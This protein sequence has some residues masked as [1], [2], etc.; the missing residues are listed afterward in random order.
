MAK[1][2]CP[3]CGTL[4]DEGAGSCAL[5][6]AGTRAPASPPV[7]AAAPAA[8]TAPGAPPPAAAH[9]PDRRRSFWEEEAANR[10]RS[11]IL[12]A[13]FVVL[14]AAVGGVTG[15]A[16]GSAR[17]GLLLCFVAGVVSAAGAY[18]GGDRV[19]L[20]ASSAREI[21]R[22]ENPQLHNIV[23]ELC[24]ASGVPKP[25]LYL[26]D[27][28]AP[29]AF[30]TGRTPDHAAV[31]VTSG[32]LAKLNREELQG[33][34]AHELSH[35]RNL[36]V[37]YAML[38]G[39]LV[40]M[41]ALVCDAQ[42]RGVRFTGPRRARGIERGGALWFILALV[43]A[44]L[45]P[46]AARLVQLAISRRRE[47]LADASAVELTRNPLGLA[48]ALRRI[49]TDPAPLEVA[50]RATQHLYIA[51]PVHAAGPDSGALWSTHPPIEARIR[52]LESMA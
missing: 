2:P 31:A 13:L 30:A 45:A 18:F 28:A 12:I 52:I 47:L 50:N 36:D 20:A 11:W 26:I 49:G 27:S 1:V 15:E 7:V 19:L 44:V 24:I 16:Y 40:G 8:T 42:L 29:N 43:L 3:R 51:N 6:G 4:N 41:V 38:V 22:E 33:V 14:L 23:E 10:R 39:V 25:R 9:R 34:L 35:V 21:T 17:I 32:L 46:I 5:C 37:R 48:A